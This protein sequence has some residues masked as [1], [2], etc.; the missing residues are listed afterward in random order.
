MSLVLEYPPPM[1]GLDI[2]HPSTSLEWV[3]WP[4]LPVGM[5]NVQSVWLNGA[6]HAGG[7]SLIVTDLRTEARL[8]SLRPGVDSEWTVTD[9]PTY[10]YALAVRNSELLLV[11]GS[12][13]PTREITNK[14]LTMRDG[15][16]FESLPLMNEKRYSPSAVSN[17][18]ALVV[19]GGYGTSGELSSSVEVLK[20]G[21]W[22]TALSLP[23]PGCFMQSALHGDQ[24]YIVHQLRSAFRVSLQSLTSG[25]DSLPW[26]TLPDA[27][28][29]YSAAAFFG[30]RFLSIGGRRLL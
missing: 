29:S 28:N 14:V 8:Y 27:P 9:T 22:T 20:D 5:N 21:Q 3:E 26:K 15:E 16:F 2:L 24:W 30:G 17:G 10:Y 23:R 7:G 13:Y 4:P 12:E 1:Q 25:T 18:S 11:G 19:A 6:V